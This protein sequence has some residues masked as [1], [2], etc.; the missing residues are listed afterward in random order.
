MDYAGLPVGPGEHI[1]ELNSRSSCLS[2]D[3]LV[4]PPQ[5]LQEPYGQAR[6]G[7]ARLCAPQATQVEKFGKPTRKKCRI[8]AKSFETSTRSPRY[9]SHE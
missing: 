2:G 3:G 9:N 6:L 1:S 5:W 4:P 7:A 8:L